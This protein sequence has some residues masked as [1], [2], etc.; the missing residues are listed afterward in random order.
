MRYVALLR[1]INVGHAK[2]VAMADLR[3]VFTEFG[4]EDV[5]TL[6][7]SGNVVFTASR[8]PSTAKIEQAVLDATGVAS[9]VTV[10]TGDD[11]GAAVRDCPL[12]VD[13]DKRFG[14]AVFAS[15]ADAQRLRPLADRD[16]S[17]EALAVGERVA[18]ISCPEGF[19]A[20]AVSD[21]IAEQVGDRV[22]TRNWATV[23]KI[24]A[25]L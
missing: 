14:L 11:L 19:R 22:T 3:D 12:T 21:A 18:Y 24:L 1:G 8:K 5:K 13:D 20:S 25:A 17:P 10:I 15:T 4:Y 7:N 23:Q 16:W 2:R 6:L 9:R